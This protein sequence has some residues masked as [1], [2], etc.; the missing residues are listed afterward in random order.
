MGNYTPPFRQ[1]LKNQPIDA[2]HIRDSCRHCI[3]ARIVLLLSWARSMA[4]GKPHSSLVQA[5][6]C[7]STWGQGDLNTPVVR[8]LAVAVVIVC[9]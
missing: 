3:H 7:A 4:D 9:V 1:R 6:G 8:T 2:G 5:S